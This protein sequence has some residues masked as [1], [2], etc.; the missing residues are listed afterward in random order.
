MSCNFASCF[1]RVHIEVTAHAACLS[2]T[3]FASRGKSLG[4]S[5]LKRQ[6]SFP[7]FLW[8][9]GDSPRSGRALSPPLTHA[10]PRLSSHPLI[11]FFPILPGHPNFP[12]MLPPF[13]GGCKAFSPPGHL[14]HSFFPRERA[15]FVQVKDSDLSVPGRG[16]TAPSNDTSQGKPPASAWRSWQLVPCL[17]DS[18]QRRSWV[19]I[20]TGGLAISLL[21]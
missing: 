17:A 12:A 1:F 10:A 6:T 20:S 8:R 11:A 14:A 15:C 18:A 5:T 4:P 7:S 21:E 2:P 16:S 19:S 13:G 3:C 9:S